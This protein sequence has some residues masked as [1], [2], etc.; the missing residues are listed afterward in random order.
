MSDWGDNSA[1][2]TFTFHTATYPY[3]PYSPQVLQEKSL[4]TSRCG[5]KQTKYAG[6]FLRIQIKLY[7]ILY[8]IISL[9]EISLHSPRNSGKRLEDSLTSTLKYMKGIIK[10]IK[11]KV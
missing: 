3:T 11:V 7:L 10:I 8:G 4:S 5:L 6:H 2:R 9:P 1:G